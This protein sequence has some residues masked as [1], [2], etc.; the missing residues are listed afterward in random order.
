M[1][2]TCQGLFLPVADLSERSWREMSRVSIIRRE[3]RSQRKRVPITWTVLS[4]VSTAVVESARFRKAAI[5]R[6]GLEV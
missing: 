1:Y 3:L 6:E 2:F 4:L 5:L